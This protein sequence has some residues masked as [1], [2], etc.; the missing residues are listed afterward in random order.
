[1]KED[2]KSQLLWL[3]GVSVPIYI[4]LLSIAGISG[5][6]TLATILMALPAAGFAFATAFYALDVGSYDNDTAG[7]ASFL[8]LAST[9]GALASIFYLFVTNGA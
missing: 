3:A 6:G 5:E 8:F 4:A 9:L 2:L 7:L 1:M